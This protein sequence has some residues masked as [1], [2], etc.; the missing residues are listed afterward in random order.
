M[1]WRDYQR[2]QIS[3]EDSA[4][5]YKSSGG[6][7]DKYDQT[8]VSVA[9]NTSGVISAGATMDSG[10]IERSKALYASLQTGEATQ[11]SSRIVT[12]G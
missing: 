1:F 6:P 2:T 5:I 4:R 10:I 7:Y 3:S 12:C 8:A 11:I 9:L